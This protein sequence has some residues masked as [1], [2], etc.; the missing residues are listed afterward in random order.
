[1]T[2]AAKQ[3]QTKKGATKAVG[4]TTGHT[5]EASETV[6]SH[7]DGVE[8]EIRPAY[9]AYI[10]AQRGLAKAFRGRERQGQ[11]AYKDAERRYQV[12]EEA[13]ER[14]MKVREKAE[15]DALDI[16]RET[17]DSAVKKAS[18]AYRE[19]MRQAL[20]DCK[21]TIEQTWRASMDT[22][23]AEMTMIFHSDTGNPKG[24]EQFRDGSPGDQI[25]RGGLR[26]K[27]LRWKSTC[28]TVIRQAVRP[29]G[30]AAG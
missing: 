7:F 16:Y 24:Q 28:A 9:R 1:M 12:C 14:A 5:A 13:I 4:E 26:E 11:E 15:R 30:Q 20:R 3:Q 29:R 27:I 25:E 10:E 19:K 6:A 17:V 21:Q 18:D 8:P 2:T 23:A 22:S